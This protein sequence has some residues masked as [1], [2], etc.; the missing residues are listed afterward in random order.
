VRAGLAEGRTAGQL[1]GVIWLID[2]I[3]KWLPGFRS[4]YMDTIMGQADGQPGCS[5]PC[6]R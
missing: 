1:R 5:A 4:G 6:S 3:V 2:A